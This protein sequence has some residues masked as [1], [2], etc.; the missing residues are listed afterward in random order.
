MTTRKKRKRTALSRARRARQGSS[1]PSRTSK[2][3]RKRKRKQQKERG[4]RSEGCG[5]D[6]K[7]FFFFLLFRAIFTKKMKLAKAGRCSELLPTSFFSPE[8]K[9]FPFARSL[10][11]SEHSERRDVRVAGFWGHPA[12]SSV[13]RLRGCSR[14]RSGKKWREA[15]ADEFVVGDR[16][17]SIFLHLNLNVVPSKTLHHRRHQHAVDAALDL[18]PL[19]DQHPATL[20]LIAAL[21]A[22]S[23]EVYRATLADV[24]RDLQIEL[25]STWGGG[26]GGGDGD[27]ATARL[28]HFRPAGGHGG[29][30]RRPPRQQRRSPLDDLNLDGSDG[31]GDGDE[32]GEDLESPQQWGLWRLRLPES[33][34]GGGGRGGSECLVVAFRGTASPADVLIDA[35]IA[36]EAL[37]PRGEYSSE[38]E[39]NG[40]RRGG[41]AGDGSSSSSSDGGGGSGG[42]GGSS[43][44]GGSER[45]EREDAV[46]NFPLLHAHH[47]FLTGARRHLRSILRLLSCH[48]GARGGGGGGGGNGSGKKNPCS[49]N[50]EFTVPVF[51]TGHSLGG[52]YAAAAALDLLSSGSAKLVFGAA[53]DLLSSGSAK[54]VF[55][56]ASVRAAEAEAQAG[57]QQQQQR[58]RRQTLSSSS[59]PPPFCPPSLLPRGGV[60]VFGAPP[61]FHCPPGLADLAHSRLDEL[62]EAAGL[63]VKE[64]NEGEGGGGATTTDTLPLPRFAFGNVVTAGDPVPRLL[65][66]GFSG[67]ARLVAAAVPSIDA[68][69]AAAQAYRPLGTVL[70]DISGAAGALSAGT[71]TAISA[72]VAAGLSSPG[73]RV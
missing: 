11:A 61:V 29:S 51:F 3:K 55:G 9:F 68:I 71:G 12:A 15:A 47:G 60:V 14:A 69:R 21:A 19:A 46:R 17:H 7:P 5:R 22:L 64:G 8:E 36:P 48:G 54:L 62:M 43:G 25:P 31:D 28:L 58:R 73:S 38:E 49:S 2:K 70:F 37:A 65:G 32:G 44:G 56:A 10:P 66:T 23:D 4:R 45:G 59:P 41:N 53:L 24:G 6:N 33:G 72:V 1:G 34:G 26:G 30:R 35:A 27:G 13:S 42:G 57:Q 50:D 67:V 52:G 20:R 16:D 63:A 18:P 40:R 39:G